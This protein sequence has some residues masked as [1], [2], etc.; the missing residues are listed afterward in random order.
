MNSIDIF[1]AIRS[2]AWSAARL[3]LSTRSRLGVHESVNSAIASVA[4][5]FG[6]TAKQE[7]RVISTCDFEKGG[8]I[9]V[10]WFNEHGVLCAA[11]E[12]DSSAK[13]KSLKKLRMSGAALKVIVSYSTQPSR[14]VIP[15][16]M[17]WL[18]L[19]LWKN[20]TSIRSRREGLRSFPV[21]GV[22]EPRET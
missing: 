22:E 17:V 14:Y 5:R 19:G 10:V 20:G 16:D 15:R 11:F 1:K 9:D 18:R 3:P 6:C 4:Q 8:R 13:R 12:T 7:W 2:A 21:V